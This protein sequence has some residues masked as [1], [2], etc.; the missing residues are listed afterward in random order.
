[1]IQAIAEVVAAVFIATNV[2]LSSLRVAETVHHNAR[3][4][5]RWGGRNAA[6]GAMD[7]ITAVAI[8]LGWAIILF[9][10]GLWR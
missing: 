6:I 3:L 7:D 8:N 1:M 4:Y 2:I 10:A 5:G 9:A